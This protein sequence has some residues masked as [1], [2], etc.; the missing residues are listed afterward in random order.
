MA[1]AFVLAVEDV[2]QDGD[3]G[4]RQHL[5]MGRVEANPQAV[6][7]PASS[8]RDVQQVVALGAV[9]ERMTAVNR[10]PLPPVRGGRVG[11]VCLG[12]EVRPRQ[13]DPIT[14]ACPDRC[15]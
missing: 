7:L 8:R 6:A 1:A 5:A 4:S 13:S 3:R 14:I 11:Q 15:G 2:Q 12:R 9:D 10:H